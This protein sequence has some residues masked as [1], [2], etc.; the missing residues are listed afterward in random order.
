MRSTGKEIALTADDAPIEPNARGC[1]CG[2]WA[3]KPEVLRSQGVEPGFC[4]V[5]V[6]CGAPGHLRHAPNG[7][8]SAA[9]CDRCFQRVARRGLLIK[10][11]IGAAI[12]AALLLWRYFA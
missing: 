10:I 5:C 12:V 11:A 7:P 9:W 2:L 4:G 8:Y 1:Y 3:T 6:K